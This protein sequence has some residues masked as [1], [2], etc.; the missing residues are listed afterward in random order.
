MAAMTPIEMFEHVA[1][2]ICPGNTW[3]A[4]IT[5]LLAV[6]RDTTRHWLNGRIPL[7]PDHFQ[8][9]LGLLAQRRALLEQTEVE[10]TQW[11]AKQEDQP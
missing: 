8:S 6:R 11:L 4:A 3:Q 10:L 7:R 9:L 2:A 5:D 1:R